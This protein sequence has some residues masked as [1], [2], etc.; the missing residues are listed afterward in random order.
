MF[1]F[2]NPKHIALK[3]VKKVLV[4]FKEALSTL[5]SLFRLVPQKIQKLTKKTQKNATLG[6]Q[7][8]LKVTFK[9]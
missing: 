1:L 8:L 5:N 7:K 9:P 6:A 4:S 3:L 2:E